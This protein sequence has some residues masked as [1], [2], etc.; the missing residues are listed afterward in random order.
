LSTAATPELISAQKLQASSADPL[1]KLRLIIRIN[2]GY[3]ILFSL[4]FL[5]LFVYFDFFW[6][7]FFLGVVL[8][9]YVLAIVYNS[10][11][12]RRVLITPAADEN[13]RIRL[14]LIY[15]RMKKALQTVEIAALFFYPFSLTAGFI[16]ALAE[17]GKLEKLS[18]EPL[19]QGLLVACFVLFV[20]LFYYLTKWLN[21][22]AFG[23]EVDRIFDLLTALDE[24]KKEEETKA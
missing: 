3:G 7:R 13:I 9:G 24:E 17:E 18:T 6:V 20:L 11:L 23:K 22:I 1:L 8:L 14:S 5:A 2:S 15:Y 12:L 10:Y 4:L 19:L 16:M 21:K